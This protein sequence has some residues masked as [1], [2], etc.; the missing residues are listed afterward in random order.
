MAGVGA[1]VGV[2]LL[3][4]LIA[5]AIVIMQQRRRLREL[6]QELKD[7]PRGSVG[8]VHDP[9]QPH[10]YGPIHQQ[11]EYFG[12]PMPELDPHA[13]RHEMYTLR[14]PQELDHRRRAETRRI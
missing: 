14:D 7:A 9:N 4:A 6:K 2:P 10:Q 5:A 11:T 12:K 1:G 13:S 3:L 8:Y